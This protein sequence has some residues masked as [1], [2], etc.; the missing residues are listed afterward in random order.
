M[1]LISTAQI[2]PLLLMGPILLA[3]PS[4][5]GLL[6]F[7]S[8]SQSVKRNTVNHSQDRGP[9]MANNHTENSQINFQSKTSLKKKK[10][11]IKQ[12][13]NLSNLRIQS[14]YCI[15]VAVRLLLEYYRQNTPHN[16]TVLDCFQLSLH[17][18]TAKK[19][20]KYLKN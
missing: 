20:V 7:T 2:S 11:S 3:S 15:L 18:H 8:K 5:Y 16:T 14:D 4:L 12:T 13:A 19:K 1:H 10:V 17:R 6:T 9:K